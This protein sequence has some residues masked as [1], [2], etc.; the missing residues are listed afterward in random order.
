[1]SCIRASVLFIVLQIVLSLASSPS[2]ADANLLFILDGSSSMWGQ[3]DGVAK[4]TTAREVLSSL[5]NDLPA[6]ANVGLMTY[7]HRREGDCEDVE[8]I[9]PIA[10]NEP[11]ALLAR[12][13]EIKPKGKTPLTL[14]L[15]NCLP[16]FKTLGGQN[17]SIVL[18]SDGKET[19]GGD[20][21]EAAKKLA[22]AGSDVRVHVVGFDVSEEERAQLECIAREGQG[23]YFGANNADQLRTAFAAVKDEVEQAPAEPPPPTKALFF[24]DN[25][26]GDD[27]QDHWEIINLV[28]DYFI[29]ENS[30]LL[31]IGATAGSL[32]Q[33]TASNLF[34]LAKDLPAGDWEMTAKVSIDFQTTYEQILLGL[35]DSPDSHIVTLVRCD[36]TA[37]CFVE[38]LKNSKGNVSQFSREFWQK[39]QPGVYSEIMKTL[40]QPLVLRLRKE[41]RSYYGGVM[42]A[43]AEEA[44]WHE[45]EKLT[46]LRGRGRLAIGVNQGWDGVKGETPV[47]FDWVKIE[48][49]E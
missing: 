7:G 13:E 16:V 30:G 32:Q 38:S 48:T 33:E 36:Y 9:F 41:G 8:F 31:M 18:V 10:P 15:E 25:F 23:R 37:A 17:N 27:L 12:A 29:V 35:Y 24:E 14:S 6:N 43:G 5:L 1:M 44:V 21:C 47:V 26:D 49:I 45:L 4:I 40:P 3:V 20:P 39:G 34:V 42:A 22:A 11:A 19:C 46:D 2:R 28:P